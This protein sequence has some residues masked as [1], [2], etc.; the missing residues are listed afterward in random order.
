MSE[1]EPVSGRRRLLMAVPLLISTLLLVAALTVVFLLGGDRAPTGERL[2]VRF[3]ASCPETA[4]AIIRAR[5]DLIGLGAPSVEATAD[6]VRLVAT[7][8][9]LPDDATA[10]PALLARRGALEVTVGDAVVAT[11]DDVL[12]AEVNLDTSGVPYTAFR[13]SPAAVARVTGEGAMVVRLDDEV[14]LEQEV[15]G[16]AEDAI[17]SVPTGADMPSRMRA[18]TDRSILLD[19]G[20]HSCDVEVAAVAAAPAPG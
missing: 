13:L 18:A 9:G 10:I 1:I 4:A 2:E 19:S 8:P 14:L 17:R 5:A 11:Q 12:T 20:A 3:A 15:A 16:L 7:M 6:G